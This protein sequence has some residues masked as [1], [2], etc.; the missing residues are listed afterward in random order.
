[1]FLVQKTIKTKKYKKKI[2][3]L[4][5]MSASGFAGLYPSFDNALTLRHGGQVQEVDVPW[6]AGSICF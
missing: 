4:T 5:S 2:E 6:V 3:G 1:M